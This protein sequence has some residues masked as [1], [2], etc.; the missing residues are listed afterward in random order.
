MDRSFVFSWRDRNWSIL[1]KKTFL[2]ANHCMPS[3][4][5]LANLRCDTTSGGRITHQVP[6]GQSVRTYKLLELCV[7]PPRTRADHSDDEAWLRFVL[8]P[9]NGILRFSRSHRKSTSFFR[10]VLV[11]GEPS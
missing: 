5:Y 6:T 1:V 8:L 9:V 10:V 3:S 4:M 11:T 7:S 2:Y